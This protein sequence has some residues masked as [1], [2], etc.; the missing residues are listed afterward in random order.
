MFLLKLLYIIFLLNITL[1]A[2]PTGY[3]ELGAMVLSQKSN[4]EPMLFH[5]DKRLTSLD[6]GPKG[7]KEIDPYLSFQYINTFHDMTLTTTLNEE[8]RLSLRAEGD[9]LGAEVFIRPSY[10]FKNPYQ[11]YTARTA[12]LV[13][14]TGLGGIYKVPLENNSSLEF[15][16]ILSKKDIL[17]DE[18]GRQMPS[19]ARDGYR[20]RVE[21]SWTNNFFKLTTGAFTTEHMGSA[22]N[23]KGADI[24]L[25]STYTYDKMQIFGTATFAHV[26]Y[27]DIN[28]FFNT[29]REQNNLK[30][31]LSLEYDFSSAGYYAIA[32]VMSNRQFSNIPFFNESINALFIG[33]GRNF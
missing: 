10:E 9:T 11:L 6:G 14:E 31:S 2:E 27:N 29:T 18:L 24:K 32:G 17:D 1:Y 4:T 19:L 30:A 13:V 5:A 26:R 25:S 21:C 23:H 7:Q 16:Y 8:D 28:P 3:I 20:H 22:E 33:M 12:T 15:A